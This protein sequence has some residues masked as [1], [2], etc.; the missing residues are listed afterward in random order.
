MA[1]LSNTEKQGKQAQKQ[2]YAV[3]KHRE[4][5]WDEASLPFTSNIRLFLHSLGDP[6]I[7]TTGIIHQ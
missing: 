4:L 2:A 5:K 1:G 3:L 7:F 6:A